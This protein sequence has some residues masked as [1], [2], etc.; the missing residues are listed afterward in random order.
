MTVQCQLRQK[1][2]EIPHQQTRPAWW[3]TLVI[4]ATW[5]IQVGG[6]RSKVSPSKKKRMKPYLKNNLKQKGLEA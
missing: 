3:F 5:E 6:L 1:V 2:S 4:P